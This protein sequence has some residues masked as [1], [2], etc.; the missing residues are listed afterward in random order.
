MMQL[1]PAHAADALEFNKISHLLKLKC[2][3]DAARERVEALR[4][5]THINYVKQALLETNEFKFILESNDYFPNDYTRNVQ[6]ELKLLAVAGAVLSGEQLL[7]L[8]QLA[9][10]TRDI[11]VWFK[12]NNELFPTLRALSENITYEKEINTIISTVVD[13]A[14]IVKDAASRELSQIRSRLAMLRQELRKA[15][16]S[17]LRKHNKQGYL[18]DIAEGFLNG[19]RVLAVLAEYKRIVKGIL[20]GESDSAQT[21]FI[22]PEETIGLSNEVF[23]LERAEAKEVQRILAQTTATLSQY[24]PQLDAYYELVGLYDFIRAKALL[25]IDMQGN[26]PQ[27]SPHPGVHLIKAHHPLL[28]LHN[29]QNNKPTI[30]LNITLDRNSRILV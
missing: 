4:F 29:K 22:E 3:T 25:A 9:F 18:A 6:K 5:H 23:S 20:H 17:V 10:N 8:R 21:V 16:E 11:L 1:Y 2:R 15:F 27:L 14:G 7:A 13:D 30:P 12:K 26:M 24:H 28:Y 19:R